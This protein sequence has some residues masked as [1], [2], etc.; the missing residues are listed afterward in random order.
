MKQPADS[1]A[2]GDTAPDFTLPGTDGRSWCYADVALGNGLVVIFICNHCP[3]VKAVVNRMVQEARALREIGVGVVAIN[4]N[5][6]RSYP[7]DSFDNMI[8][9]ARQHG[10]GFPY[11]LDESQTVARAYGAQCTPEFFGLDSQRV[12]R[13]RG[14][15]DSAARQSSGPVAKRDLFEAMQCVIDTGQGPADQVASV[16]CS[17]KWK[18]D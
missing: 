13:Y 9:F 7:E 17:I 18:R 4:S 8:G 12:L 11:L 2:L 14:R 16:G 1:L 6:A 5:D 3:Y 10:F 15:L